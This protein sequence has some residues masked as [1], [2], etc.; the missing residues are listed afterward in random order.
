MEFK[1]HPLNL[2][3]GQIVDALRESGNGMVTVTLHGE[4]EGAL[5]VVLDGEDAPQLAR[6]LDKAQEAPEEIIEE[7]IELLKE[8]VAALEEEE[9]ERLEVE[10]NLR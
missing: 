3:V 4:H 2:T 5:V 6:L 8:A 1:T 7:A 9:A 10:R